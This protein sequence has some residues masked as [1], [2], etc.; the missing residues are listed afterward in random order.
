MLQTN[1]GVL[2]T[3]EEEL[4]FSELGSYRS[5]QQEAW[6][7]QFIFEGSPTCLNFQKSREACSIERWRANGVRSRWMQAGAFPCRQIPLDDSGHTRQPRRKRAPW[8]PTG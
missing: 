2:T 8:W 6:R 1:K 4:A 3:F 5:P 7:R